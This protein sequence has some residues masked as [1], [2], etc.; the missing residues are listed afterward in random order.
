MLIHSARGEDGS[1]VVNNNLVLDVYDKRGDSKHTSLGEISF[2]V[3][4]SVRVTIQVLT[5]DTQ[6]VNTY[7]VSSF[8]L[9][10]LCKILIHSIISLI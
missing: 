3:E 1:L 6:E 2:R 8:L 7:S 4:G 10:G 9:C 5:P